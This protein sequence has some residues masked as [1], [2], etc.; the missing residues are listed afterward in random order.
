MFIFSFQNTQT[1]LSC[2]DILFATLVTKT[3]RL[4][5]VSTRTLKET[6]FCKKK[7]KNPQTSQRMQMFSSTQ[8]WCKQECQSKFFFSSSNHFLCRSQQ[9][10]FQNCIKVPLPFGLHI[11]PFFADKQAGKLQ[12]F[13]RHSVP[14]AQKLGDLRK[15]IGPES[16]FQREKEM[17]PSNFP[18]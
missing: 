8:T 14:T 10:W 15:D 1:E 5:R 9:F 7:Q 2:P 18:H 3:C 13:Q 12:I 11:W 6:Y 4:P 17:W 16:S